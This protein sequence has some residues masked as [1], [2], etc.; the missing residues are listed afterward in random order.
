MKPCIIE[1][2]GNSDADFERF[3]A[4][5]AVTWPEA[6]LVRE[7]PPTDAQIDAA[8]AADERKQLA[9]AA[10]RK[11]PKGLVPGDRRRVRIRGFKPRG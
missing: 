10:R 3:R 4:R 6:R 2:R 1:Y 8:A 7:K 5:L 9:Q 11:I